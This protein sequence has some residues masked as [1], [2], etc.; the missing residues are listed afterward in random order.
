MNKLKIGNLLA[1]ISTQVPDINLRKLIKLVY[2]IDE[3]SVVSKGMSV[4]W[5]EYYVWEKGPVAPCIYETKYNN[6]GDFSRY[7]STYRNKEEKVIV[8]SII[9]RDSSSMQFSKN[10]LKL[11]DAVI[12]KY[13]R[14]SADELS[15]I[16]HRSGGLWDA[17]KKKYRPNFKESD[18]RSDIKLNLA[19]LICGDDEKMSVY[20][21]A[22]DI[23]M[24]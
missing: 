4:T 16:T 5:L 14:M 12:D 19:D 8:R 10:E 21:D 9:N 13:G 22:R 23:A 15:E 18:G 3:K 6:G 2:L 24:L 11:I 7:I 17:A 20:E 1:Y